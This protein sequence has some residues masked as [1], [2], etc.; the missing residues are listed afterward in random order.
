[1]RRL[2]SSII[3]VLIAI[4]VLP[5][6]DARAITRTFDGN[7]AADCQTALPVYDGNVR[8]RPLAVQNEGSD[9]AFVTCSFTTQATDLSFVTL[10]LTNNNTTDT[11][12]TCTGVSGYSAGPTQYLPQTKTVAA[13]G[14]GSMLWSPDSIL[15]NVSCNLPPGV[16]IGTFRV[17]FQE[18]VGL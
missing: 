9:N 18:D 15:F 13:S 17:V 6:G 11:P 7:A 1:M 10:F 8:K 14:L 5:S 12:V 4:A 3:P 16:G 2:F